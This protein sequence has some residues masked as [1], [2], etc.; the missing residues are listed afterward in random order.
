MSLLRLRPIRLIPSTSKVAQYVFDQSLSA[1]RDGP[2]RKIRQRIFRKARAILIRRGDPLI[3]YEL[4]GTPMYLPISHQLPFYRAL[5][6]LYSSNVG[7]IARAVQQKYSDL[8]FVDVG[9]NVGDTAAIVRAQARFPIL[10]IEGNP[11]FFSILE[12]NAQNLQPDLHL[13]QVFIGT[14]EGPLHARIASGDGTARVTPAGATGDAAEV[15]EMTTLTRVTERHREFA[16]PRMLKIDTDGYDCRILKNEAEFLAKI[17]PVI[18]FEYD[19]HLFTLQGDDGFAVFAT[20]LKGGYRK[21]LFYDNYGDYLLAVDL[22]NTR[23]LEDIHQYYSGRGLERYCDI[24]LFAGE[25]GDL[26]DKIRAEEIQFF[27]RQR[28]AKPGEERTDAC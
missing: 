15:L 19:P 14:G 9:A 25:D 5:F 3:E 2:R 22:E 17:R 16:R 8:A 28:Q 23:A 11:L 20:L 7:R 6:P 21:A 13:E 1:A 18:F 24:C 26:A 27:A 4:E 12:L 10:C